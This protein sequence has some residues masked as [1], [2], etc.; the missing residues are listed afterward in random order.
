MQNKIQNGFQIRQQMWHKSGW[1]IRH[2]TRCKHDA[3]V[4]AK[5][6]SILDTNLG[7]NLG[8]KLDVRLGP[9]PDTTNDAIVDTKLDS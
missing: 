3:K 5:R 2:N 9:K 7:A 1:K 6:D 4:Y 8:T